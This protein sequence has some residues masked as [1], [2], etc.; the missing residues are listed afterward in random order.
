MIT[1]QIRI[2]A[3]ALV[4]LVILGWVG[5]K[6]VPGWFGDESVAGQSLTEYMVASQ[7]IRELDFEYTSNVRIGDPIFARNIDGEL[8]QVGAIRQV[9]SAESQDYDVCYCDW[10]SVVFFSSAPDLQPGD[11]L[12]FHQTPTSM[13]WVARFLFPPETQSEIIGML[14]EVY[15]DHSEAVLS[16][17]KPILQ[18][19][20]QETSVI[21]RDELLKS[22]SRHRS[23][24]EALGERYRTEI[25]DKE[26]LP[27]IGDEVWPI[28][29]EE[30]RP[31]LEQVGQQ[32][33]QEASVFRFGWRALYDASPLPQKDL[34]S[35]EFTRFVED[36][37]VPVL[38]KNLPAFLEAQQ[39]IMK[40]VIANPEVQ[41][42]VANSLEKISKDPELQRIILQV[43]K[44]SILENEALQSTMLDVWNRPDLQYLKQLTD[45]KLE[46]TVVAIGEK[47]FGSPYTG[48]TPEFA[49]ILRNKILLKDERWFILNRVANWESPEQAKQD[50]PPGQQ[51]EGLF[52]D[53]PLVVKHKDDKVLAVLPGESNMENPFYYPA[54]QR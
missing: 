54:R 31:V 33:W 27:V 52:A 48:V 36:E 50:V 17:L 46:P 26:L 32:I 49:R 16:E 3:G 14:T 29:R 12:T 23:E 38:T 37:A 28:V 19:A 20:W 9:D 7:E 8:V 1:R 43:L 11:Y 22:L 6:Y 10:A 18:D 13:D 21:I 42:V 34:T 30:G 15:T 44:E 5:I 25:V 2:I 51:P 4:W 40:Q 47:V 53:H 35:T 39:S 24:F 45:A 41:A